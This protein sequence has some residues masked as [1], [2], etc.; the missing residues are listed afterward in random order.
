MMQA[1]EPRV[2]QVWDPGLGPEVFEEVQPTKDKKGL[3]SLPFREGQ[4]SNDETL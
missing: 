3:V 4:G 1:D 2:G